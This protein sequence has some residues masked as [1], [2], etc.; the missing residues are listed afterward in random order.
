LESSKVSAYNVREEREKE[1]EGKTR[2]FQKRVSIE[3]FSKKT[4]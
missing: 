2:E 3:Q 4:K 1:K